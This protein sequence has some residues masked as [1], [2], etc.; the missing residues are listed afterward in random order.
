[1]AGALP[2]NCRRSSVGEGRLEGGHLVGRNASQ[3]L[4]VSADGGHLCYDRA[5]PSVGGAQDDRVAAG[6][7]AAPQADPVR[8]YEG[9]ALQEGDGAAPVGD[10]H[11]RVDVVA[12]R[13]LA[14]PEAAVVVYHHN[15]TRVSEHSGESLK[16]VV[17]HPGETVRH[18]DGW[19]WAWTVRL[20]QPS[21][22]H[23]IA[24]GGE[25]DVLSLHDSL[26]PEA[27]KRH[28]IHDVRT[29]SEEGRPP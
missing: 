19:V 12:R 20:K 23:H 22:Q 27:V 24:L 7:T 13:A 17:L 11:P 9:E 5:Q 18:R 28:N 1:M 21:P 14:G 6:I 29:S 4:L 26:L 3:A 16:P 8:V 15:E 10:L 25:F 2:P